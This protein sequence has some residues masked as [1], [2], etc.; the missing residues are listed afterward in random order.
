MALIK[1]EELNKFGIGA[2]PKINT[3]NPMQ[4]KS[5]SSLSYGGEQQVFLN[6]ANSIIP[7][8]VNTAQ[9]KVP[10]LGIVSSENSFSPKL[11]I[12]RNPVDNYGVKTIPSVNSAEQPALGAKPVTPGISQASTTNPP[13]AADAQKAIGA[14]PATDVIDP[15]KV[16]AVQD[17]STPQKTAPVS[18]ENVAVNTPTTDNTKNA[19]GVYANKLAAQSQDILAKENTSGI[20]EDGT[21][22]SK[23]AMAVG[24]GL[25]SR[26][27]MNRAKTYAD[28]SAQESGTGISQQN[29]NVNEFGARS[30]AAERL[31]E[32]ARQD[33]ANQVDVSGKQISNEAS[34]RIN[35]LQS[36][37]MTE[38]DPAKRQAIAEQLTALTGKTTDKFTPV[39]GKDELGNSTYLGAFDNRTG[40][41]VPQVGQTQLSN[42]GNAQPPDG[43]KL[44][45]TS[46]GKPVYED[47]K[48]N[49]F[50]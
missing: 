35:N 8:K 44:V 40:N 14:R 47:A 10:E 16:N 7:A 38:K 3:T 6:N 20:S 18:A 24:A 49:R 42:V 32:S 31:K 39:I 27:L 4:G 48:G 1:D 12:V 19:Y 41:Y 37:Y 36:S 45:G 2:R 5:P 33:S 22:I 28:M 43:M 29:S 13:I 23:G 17:P 9:G 21:S 46:G 11:S 26:G 50:Q 30:Q 34:A 15:N 25:V